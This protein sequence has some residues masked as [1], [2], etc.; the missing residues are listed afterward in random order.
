MGIALRLE[1]SPWSEASLASS[2]AMRG[3]CFLRAGVRSSEGAGRSLAGHGRVVDR[4]LRA[5]G[6]ASP[7]GVVVE[8]VGEEEEAVAEW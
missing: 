2:V 6:E 7:R 3:L 4:V 1:D 8:V 5:G